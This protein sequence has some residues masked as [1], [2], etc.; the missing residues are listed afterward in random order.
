MRVLF[1]SGVLA[2][3]LGQVLEQGSDSWIEVGTSVHHVRCHRWCL[4]S[5]CLNGSL[6][7]PRNMKFIS[8]PCGAVPVHPCT[9]AAG[10]RWVWAAGSDAPTS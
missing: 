2:I 1:V 7:S 3:A 10:G 9:H 6:V 8:R 5:H 4:L